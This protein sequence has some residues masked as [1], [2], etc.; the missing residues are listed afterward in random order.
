MKKLTII[1]GPQ[2]SGKTTT[3]Q[4]YALKFRAIPII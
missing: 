3:A 2:G 4:K 1:T